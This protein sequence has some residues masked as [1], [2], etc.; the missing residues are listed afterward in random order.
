MSG[1]VFTHQVFGHR[2]EIE[3][4]QFLM[5]QMKCSTGHAHPHD[6][7]PDRPVAQNQILMSDSNMTHDLYLLMH[8]ISCLHNERQW[9]VYSLLDMFTAREKQK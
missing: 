9:E 4:G 1:T 6:P 5:R 8:L 7:D 3:S 2:H